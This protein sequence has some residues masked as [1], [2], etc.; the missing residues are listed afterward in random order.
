M[1]DTAEI[2]VVGGGKGGVGKSSTVQSIAAY[3]RLHGKKVLIIDADP[4][5]TT[6]GWIQ[7]RRENTNLPNIP[8]RSA[9]GDI[10][11]DL[12]EESVNYDYIVVDPCGVD[13]NDIES[14]ELRSALTL[15]TKFL[16]PLRPKRRDIKTLGHIYSILEM[17][18]MEKI[19]PNLDVRAVI[20]QCPHLQSQEY[21]VDQAK[22]A[23]LSFDIEPLQAVTRNRNSYDDCDEGGYSV[24]E[25]TDEKAKEETF[26]LITQFLGE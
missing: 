21:R 15:A 22:Q 5:A 11:Q 13:P 12:I 20:T 14:K 10:S 18:T 26:N 17:V 24:L 4:Q 19:N 6:M 23:C 9:Y 1:S 7:E 8:C 25:Y 16:I 2:I 3:L